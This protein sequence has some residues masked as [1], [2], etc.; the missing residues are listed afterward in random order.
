MENVIKQ[1]FIILKY[2]C[3]ILICAIVI[4]IATNSSITIY[5]TDSL[6]QSDTLWKISP[7]SDYVD[8]D[9]IILLDS[10]SIIND[11]LP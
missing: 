1:L 2:V 8:F 9:P 10:T 7:S 11:T 6:T 4:L 5:P 3:W